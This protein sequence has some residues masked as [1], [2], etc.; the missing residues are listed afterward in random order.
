MCLIVFLLIRF[1]ISDIAI[2]WPIISNYTYT[3]HSSVWIQ[4]T[5]Y[6]LR[7]FYTIVSAHSQQY[8]YTYSLYNIYVIVR[9]WPPLISMCHWSQLQIGLGVGPKSYLLTDRYQLPLPL[10]IFTR[11]LS[12]PL[13]IY[14]SHSYSRT[15]IYLILTGIFISVKLH[16]LLE[17]AQN[18]IENPP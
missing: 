18:E 15:L 16:S 3:L 7:R 8:S 12:H 10:L 6:I 13:Y 17:S 9:C 4:G 1:L 2:H 5:D 14:I 11:Y